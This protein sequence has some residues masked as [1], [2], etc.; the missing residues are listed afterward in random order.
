MPESLEDLKNKIKRAVRGVRVETCGR[1]VRE[2]LRRACVC[3]ERKGAHIEHV[4]YIEDV[5]VSV[6][7]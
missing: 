2:A 5:S 6:S 1:M 4:L 7:F 3:L